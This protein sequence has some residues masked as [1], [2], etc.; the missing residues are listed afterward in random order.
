[1]EHSRLPQ[2]KSPITLGNIEDLAQASLDA[3]LRILACIKSVTSSFISSVFANVPVKRGCGH[4][5]LI[6]EAKIVSC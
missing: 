3:E 5:V 1:M 4:S 2:L 6:T